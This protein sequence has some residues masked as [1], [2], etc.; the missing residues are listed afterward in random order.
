M[1][2]QVESRNA[3]ILRQFPPPV[4]REISPGDLTPVMGGSARIGQ[5][6]PRARCVEAR[7]THGTEGMSGAFE[8]IR[9]EHQRVL[10]RAAGIEALLPG[11]GARHVGVG[12][13]EAL[14]EALA[15]FR[16][17]FTEHVAVED[18][19]LFPALVE[20]LPET[21]QSVTPLEGEH[22]ELRDMLARLSATLDEPS[23]TDRDEQVGVQLRD[24]IDL[25]R[26]HLRKEEALV[27]R[28]AERVL[29]PR[30]VQALAARMSQGPR[31]ERGGAPA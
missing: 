30:D 12:E 24:F 6:N 28:V 2:R 21:R 1:P 26:I 16:D 7:A 3:L 29:R 27:I 18:E 5:D 25:L 14:L 22:A 19:V 17:Q 9:I 4:E 8:R 11:E 31:P 20:A 23:G 15:L 10:E 13:T